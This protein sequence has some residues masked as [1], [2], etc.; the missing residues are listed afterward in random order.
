MALFSCKVALRIENSGF[1]P[2]RVVNGW[3]INPLS[4]SASASGCAN[5]GNAEKAGSGGGGEALP[6]G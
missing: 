2:N 5:A 6:L 3:A 1:A 4:E